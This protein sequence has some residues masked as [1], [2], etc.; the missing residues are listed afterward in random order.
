MP[1][2]APCLLVLPLEGLGAD[3]PQQAFQA[4]VRLQ[5]AQ[6]QVGG[7]EGRPR[8]LLGDRVGLS[9]PHLLFGKQ[10][11]GELRLGHRGSMKRLS[12]VQQRG[13]PLP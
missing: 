5:A 11:N 2:G 13:P 4:G 1:V 8:G 10:Q 6:V 7:G 12:L 9:G 3:V